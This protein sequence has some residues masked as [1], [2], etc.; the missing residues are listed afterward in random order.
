MSQK[1]PFWPFWPVISEAGWTSRKKVP[2]GIRLK[3]ARRSHMRIFPHVNGAELKLL[4]KNH[5]AAGGVPLL[6]LV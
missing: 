6:L 5:P 4:T 1:R 2:L 3:S